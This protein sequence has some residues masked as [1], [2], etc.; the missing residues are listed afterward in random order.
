MISIGANGNKITY[1]IKHFNVD[2][3][4]DFQRLSNQFKMG[5]TCFVIETSKHYMLN[6]KNQWVEINPIG[7]SG[8]SSGGNGSSSE[9]DEIIYDGGDVVPS[10]EETHIIYDGGNA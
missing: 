6:G 4:E 10:E 2:T 7:S 1:G 8:T 3:E 5:S 9:D